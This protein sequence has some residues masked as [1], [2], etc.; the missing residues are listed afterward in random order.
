MKIINKV[1]DTKLNPHLLIN[2][3]SGSG[4]TT[5]VK[6][7]IKQNHKQ[8]NIIFFS[9]KKNQFPEWKDKIN[10]YSD[11]RD[12]LVII[13]YLLKNH[14]KRPTPILLII[15][16]LIVLLSKYPQLEKKLIEVSAIGR[17][18]GLNLV[19]L[20]QRGSYKFYAGEIKANI[21]NVVCLKTM[22]KDR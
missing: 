3:A 7:V 12:L 1:I 22:T 2:G 17:E 5:F 18:T 15:D 4:K 9:P 10:I 11:I 20:T 14:Y 13:D 6:E 21:S 19:L 8:Y 16:E